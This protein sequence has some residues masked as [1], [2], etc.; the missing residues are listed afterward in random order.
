[1]FLKVLELALLVLVALGLVTQVL[2]PLWNNRRLF[3]IWRRK[4][5]QE[6]VVRANEL[7]DKVAVIKAVKQ[8]AAEIKKDLE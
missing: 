4:E 3:P 6:A 2:I 8:T 7:G 1:M 5:L